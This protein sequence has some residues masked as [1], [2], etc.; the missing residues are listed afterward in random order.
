M[1]NPNASD[2]YVKPTSGK[3]V[4]QGPSALGSYITT[5][6]AQLK[7]FH[8]ACVGNY[9]EVGPTI[10][11]VGCTVPAAAFTDFGRFDIAN[12]GPFTFTVDLGSVSEG[13]SVNMTKA[14]LDQSQAIGSEFHFLITSSDSSAALLLVDNVILSE[15]C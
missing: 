6:F 15:Q 4:A 3:L 14:V 9:P 12:Y 5:P 13:S 10:F 1:V 2:Y 8:F 7:S 11:P